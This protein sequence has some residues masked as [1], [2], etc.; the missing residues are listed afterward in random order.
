[1]IVVRLVVVMMRIV[2]LVCVCHLW[3]CIVVV[4]A[5]EI[6]DFYHCCHLVTKD[7]T[8]YSSILSVFFRLVNFVFCSFRSLQQYSADIIVDIITSTTTSI[9]VT[10]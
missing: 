10:D 4:L 9:D 5:A 7:T 8:G 3:V 1:M 6:A 2:W